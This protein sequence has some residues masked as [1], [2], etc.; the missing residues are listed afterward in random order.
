MSMSDSFTYFVD[1]I[2]GPLVFVIGMTGN[3]ISLIV[4]TSTKL[5]NI[6]NFCL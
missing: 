3:I 1:S 4:L 6:T 2:F 5:K